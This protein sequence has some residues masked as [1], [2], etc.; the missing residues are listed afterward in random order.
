MLRLLFVLF[1][2][3][4]GPEAFCES[5]SQEFFL[6]P[7]SEVDCGERIKIS[8]FDKISET[9]IDN[10]MGAIS[11]GDSALV[12]FDRVSNQLLSYSLDG[13]INWSVGSVG[14]GPEDHLGPCEPIA[15]DG[16]TLGVA[17]YSSQPKVIL[18]SES[19]EFEGAVNFFGFQQCHQVEYAK[20]GFTAICHETVRSSEG[21]LLS[22]SL[23]RFGSTGKPLKSIQVKEIV[24]EKPKK[25]TPIPAGVWRP[26]PRM[27]VDEFG[28][29]YIQNDTRKAKFDVYNSNLEFVKTLGTGWMGAEL[30]PEVIQLDLERWSDSVAPFVLGPAGEHVFARPGGE[31]WVQLPGRTTDQIEFEVMSRLNETTGI[32]KI[33]GMPSLTGD[34]TIVGD[35]L[36][37]F[38][39]MDLADREGNCIGLYRMTT[40]Q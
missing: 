13:D 8:L 20:G 10:L 3:L 33:T 25:G 38:E 11:L 9:A 28:Y 14:S 21:F 2:V 30:S 26:F 16:R 5:I 12:I 40:Y 27:C 19:G 4:M 37:W 1:F 23:V 17:D 6:E 35:M 18:Y 34:F 15:L 32:V 39:E 36:L 7:L 24:M 22:I 29:V 31:L